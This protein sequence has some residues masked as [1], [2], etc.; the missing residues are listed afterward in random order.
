MKIYRK[1]EVRFTLVVMTIGLICFVDDHL[2]EWGRHETDWAG[3]ARVQELRTLVDRDY[4]RFEAVRNHLAA[5]LPPG[6]PGELGSHFDWEGMA[7][8]FP[9]SAIAQE[10]RDLKA[11]RSQLEHNATELN[12]LLAL[13]PEWK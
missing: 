10:L 8:Q 13:H 1:T 9:R 5:K 12:S 6:E 7:L 4:Q 11:V 2:S 3:R